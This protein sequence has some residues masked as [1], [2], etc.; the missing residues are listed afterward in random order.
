MGNSNKKSFLGSLNNFIY[1]IIISA[2]YRYWIIISILIPSEFRVESSFC[3]TILPYIML[4]L[5]LFI[6][7]NII[8]AILLQL[9]KNGPSVGNWPTRSAVRIARKFANNSGAGGR[10][11][12]GRE[13]GGKRLGGW[14]RALSRRNPFSGERVI[15]GKFIIVIWSFLLLTKS[16]TPAVA[17]EVKKRS[18]T[19]RLLVKLRARRGEG[20]NRML[21]SVC[22]CRY[23]EKHAPTL[24]WILINTSRHRCTVK[25]I[26]TS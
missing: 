21:S 2:I 18:R 25:L 4:I 14:R 22:V 5:S 15:N 6:Q 12:A 19:V 1:S 20:V 11:G 23:K 7:R 24:R 17:A 8:A 3:Y 13:G 16:E 26:I 10:G 9:L